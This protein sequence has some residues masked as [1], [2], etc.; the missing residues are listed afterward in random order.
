MADRN[1]S[2]R[3][4]GFFLDGLRGNP[5]MQPGVPASMPGLAGHTDLLYS[6]WDLGLPDVD[7]LKEWEREFADF[8]AKG[9]MPSMQF[10]Y[11]PRDHTVGS[12][13]G[14]FSPQA[15]VADNDLALGHLVDDVSHSRFWKDTAIFV[16]EDDAQDGPDHVD[17]HRTVA[18]AISPY[19]QIGKVDSTR[20]STVSMLRTMEM[21][22]G[23][24]P[25]TKYDALA[26]PMRK[27]FSEHPDFK[28]FDARLPQ[29]SMKE[30]NRADAPLAKACARQDFS[31]P[32]AA[33]ARILNEAI[34]KSVKGKK[35]KMPEPRTT[36]AV[37]D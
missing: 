29:V 23:V 36:V 30:R 14:D 20:Y 32:D 28:P 31:R 5:L 3:N 17:G 35:A 26:R 12:A 18:L 13:E 33:D 24:D 1:I 22:M 10:L 9:Q 16:V 4:Y 34:W 37:R 21:I 27:S 25:L 15:M 8:K 6:G 19:T 2:Y 7:R 11:L